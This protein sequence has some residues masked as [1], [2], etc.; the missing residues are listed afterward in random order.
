MHVGGRGCVPRAVSG[1]L[2]YLKMQ[3][4]VSSLSLLF[5]GKQGPSRSRQYGL[6]CRELLTCGL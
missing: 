3:L 5:G 1:S 6:P 2:A 4:T